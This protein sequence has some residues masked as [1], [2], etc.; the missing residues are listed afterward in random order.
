MRLSILPSRSFCDNA[1]GSAPPGGRP[2][3]GSAV[4]DCVLSNSWFTVGFVLVGT[5]V[6]AKRKSYR[7]LAAAAVAGTL[8]D[9]LYSYYYSCRDLIAAYEASRAASN[10]R[11]Q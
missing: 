1:S 11:S 3:Q 10:G 2:V 9:A 7:P 5:Y 6:G 4:T 8:C